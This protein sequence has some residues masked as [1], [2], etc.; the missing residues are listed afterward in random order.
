MDEAIGDMI[1][2]MDQLSPEYCEALCLTELEGM[3]Q[4]EYAQIRGLS[5]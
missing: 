4:K 3:S 2:M 5:Y 1:R